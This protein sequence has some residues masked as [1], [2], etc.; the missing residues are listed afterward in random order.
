MNRTRPS[1]YT[2]HRGARGNAL[3][4]AVILLLLASV[5]TLLTLNVGIFEQ[6]TSGN[7]ARAKLIAEVAESGIAQGA[8][9]FRLQPALLKP[10]GNWVRCTDDTFPCGSISDPGRRDTMYFWQNAAGGVDINNDS[11][12]DVLDQRMLPLANV[13]PASGR[14]SSVGNFNSVSYGVGVVL[15]RIKTPDDP[16]DPTECS[17]NPAT[18][19]GTFVYNYV[20]VAALP[21]E[22]T[23]TTVSQMLGQ[24]Q[25]F[26]PN[27]NQPP[28]MAS[29]SVDV[30]G[31]LQIVTN[32]NGGGSDGSVPVS[33]WTRRD[34]A[35]TGTPNT[36]YIDEF[37]RYGAK[38]SAPP[39]IEENVAVCDTCGCP[40]DSTLSYDKSGNKQDEGMDILDIDGSNGSNG[41]GINADVVPSEFPCDLFEYVFGLKSRQDNDGD[42]FCETLVPSVQYTSPTTMT[43]VWLDAD[44]AYLYKNATKIIPR[45]AS[46][47]SL[48]KPTQVLSGGYPSSAIS[49]IVWCQ[50]NCDLGANTQIGTPSK[51]VL[52]VIDGAAR[53]QGRVFGMVFLRTAPATPGLHPL[54]A[55]H[56]H[57]GDK[58]DPN[59]GGTATLD[60][61]SGATVYGAVVV[62]GQINKANGTAAIVF[63]GDIFKNFSNS[64]PASNSNLPGAWTDRLSY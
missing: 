57:T 25:I 46:A 51:P 28:I 36:C 26:N 62:Q 38:N 12:T 30:T 42:F 14:V 17:T 60:M 32:P 34:I 3:V 9:F 27:L 39:T 31:G 13:V 10:S 43:Q 58:L 56:D 37:F 2:L 49:G 23:R 16:A 4:V 7:D 61:N 15:C 5:I 6:R 24:Y 50:T 20:S 54:N 40:S 55:A 64:I 1:T 22:G 11:Q 29:G 21:G 18:Q 48:M 8:E 53:I 63:N 47:A 44:E 52:L 41:K 19:S 45:D 35:K 33:V 59:T